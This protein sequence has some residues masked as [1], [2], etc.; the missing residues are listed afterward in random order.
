[1]DVHRMTVAGVA[2]AGT[3]D[4]DP[5]EYFDGHEHVGELLDP[6]V[7]GAETTNAKQKDLDRLAEFGVYETLERSEL[8][9][10]GSWTA[11]KTESERDLSQESSRAMKLCT[12]SSR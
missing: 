2:K 10:A 3:E 4:E 1:M 11:E 8:R 7:D 5:A 12:M 9:H 6:L